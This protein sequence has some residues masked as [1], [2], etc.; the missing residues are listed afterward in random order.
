MFTE[1]LSAIASIV[2]SISATTA[3]IF[4]YR[5]RA[6]IRQ[7]ATRVNGQHDELVGKLDAMTDKRDTLVDERE[8]AHPDTRTTPSTP[9]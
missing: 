8:A 1:T 5:N 9:S 7:V 2:G 3:V 4:G 6:G